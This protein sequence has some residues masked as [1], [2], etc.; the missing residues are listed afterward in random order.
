MLGV[1]AHDGAAFPVPDAQ[2]HAGGALVCRLPR[3]MPRAARRPAA[4][5]FSA[6]LGHDAGA[7]V[8]TAAAALVAPDAAVDGLLASRWF[9]FLDELADD[10]LVAP[11][12]ANCG[13]YTLKNRF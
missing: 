8:E 12:Q 3:G 1:L 6:S 13:V 10:L 11:T 7:A 2:A 5:T 4:I 9:A